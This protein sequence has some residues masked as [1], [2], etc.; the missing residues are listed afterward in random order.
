MKYTACIGKRRTCA[1]RLARGPKQIK[2]R[3][4]NV[5]HL[6]TEL[7]TAKEKHKRTRVTL[8]EKELTLKE[9]ENRILDVRSKLNSCSSNREYQAFMEQIAADDQ[10][11]SVLSDEIL[12]LLDKVSEDQTAITGAEI[13]VADSNAELEK[14][15]EKVESERESLEQDL[16]RIVSQLKEAEKSLPAA[17]RQEYD[18]AVRAHGEEALAALEGECCGGCYQR[19]TTQMIHELTMQQAVFCKSCGRLLYLAEDSKVS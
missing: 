6:E 17:V 12:E 19:I 9:R 16:A 5:A 14:L 7:E 11:N 8:A 1:D 18:R 2:A 15:S 13:A 3:Q 4:A 10:A